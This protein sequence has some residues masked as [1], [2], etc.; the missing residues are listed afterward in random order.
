MNHNENLRL[1]DFSVTPTSYLL[2]QILGGSYAAYEAFFDALPGLDIEQEWQWYTPHK[3]WFG[4]GQ[5]FWTTARGAQKE[6]TLYWLHVFEGYFNVVVWFKEKNRA[7][8]LYANVSEKTKELIRDAKTMGKV[9]TFPVTFNVTTPEPL[10]DI[11]SLLG[12]KK[13]MEK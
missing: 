7:E 1:R 2:E 6:K 9:P 5:H 12:C 3:A 10:T 8:L 4:R 13:K 11:Y